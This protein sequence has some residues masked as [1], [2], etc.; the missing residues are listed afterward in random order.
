VL[1][2]HHLIR[3]QGWNRCNFTTVVILYYN[4]YAVLYTTTN[5]PK[6]ATRKIIF[7]K[8]KKIGKGEERERGRGFTNN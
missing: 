6:Q 4:Q 8:D 1:Y 5:T 7:Q 3:L 2:Q